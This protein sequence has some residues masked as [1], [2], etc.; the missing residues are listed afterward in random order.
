MNMKQHTWE[1]RVLHALLIFVW[2]FTHFSAKSSSLFQSPSASVRAPWLHYYFIVIIWL[3]PGAS[4]LLWYIIL[5]I[6]WLIKS[7]WVNCS[8]IDASSGCNCCNFELSY[9]DCCS[10]IGIRVRSLKNY[11]FVICS[12]IIVGSMSR[13]CIKWLGNRCRYEFN[14][15]F[16]GT[17]LWSLW[18]FMS[19]I[20]A[21]LLLYMTIYED[22]KWDDFLTRFIYGVLIPF[23]WH[24]VQNSW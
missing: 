11:S 2:S 17:S 14:P 15:Y 7:H 10:M 3:I 5:W 9:L 21:L 22:V 16:E 4:W 20:H 13:I 18:S 23:G 24:F 1:F 8:L 19:F 12:L 6:T